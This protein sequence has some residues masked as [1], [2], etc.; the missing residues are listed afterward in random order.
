MDAATTD[1]CIEILLQENL[2]VAVKERLLHAIQKHLDR[3]VQGKYQ[4]GAVVF[5]NVYGEL[6]KTSGADKLIADWAQKGG[7]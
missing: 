6:G 4:V 7:N 3:R 1:A 5:S 2:W